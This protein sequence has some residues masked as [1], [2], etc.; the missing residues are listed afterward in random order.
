MNFF[1]DP[2]PMIARLLLA[3]FLLLGLAGTA[4]AQRVTYDTLQIDYPWTGEMPETTPPFD[5]SVMMIIRN[6]G[7]IADALIAA[8]SP[9]AA[10]VDIRAPN[11]AIEIKPDERIELTMKGHHLRLVGVNRLIE[12]YDTFPLALTFR[13]AGRIEV[14]VTVEEVKVDP[15]KID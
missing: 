5:L 9:I 14:E 11:A 4:S 13:H 3:T 8:S 10:R 15:A 2:V 12:T 1:G 7:E 6:T